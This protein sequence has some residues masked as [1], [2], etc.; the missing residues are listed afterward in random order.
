VTTNKE[1]LA[2][3]EKATPRGVGIQTEIFA[4]KAK[5]AEI[6]DVEGNRYIDLGT[7]IAVLATGHNHPRVIKAVKAQLERFSHTCFQVT[8]YDVYVR[9]AERLNEAAPGATPKKTFFVNTG[10]EAVE[11]TVKIARRYTG[12]SGVIA[13]SGAFHGRTMM[14]MALTG[15]VLPY[16]AGFGP[17]PAEV[18]HVPFP[19]EYH[20]VSV[21]ESLDALQTLFRSDVEPSRIAA[22]VVEPV[23]GEGG[24]YPAPREFLQALR[25]LCDEHGIV[26]AIDEVQTGFGRT[27]TLF[28]CEQAGIEPDLMPVAKS[29]AGGF[30]LAGVIGKA[31][32]MDA[33]DPGGLGST[34]GGSPIGCAAGLAVLDIIEEEGLCARATAIGEQFREWAEAL[35]SQTD[36]VGDIRI[37]GAMCAVEF[38]EGGTADRPAAELTKAIVTDALTQGVLLLTCG[39]RGNVIRFL[40]ALTIEPELLAEALDKTGVI[41]KRLAGEMRK[42][43]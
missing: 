38:V 6:W 2:I 43:S 36:C 33:A 18:Y 13:F 5:N 21:Q 12:R 26:L 8:P 15:K 19:I 1:L 31:E 29:I 37:M 24:F 32:I 10:A 42:A 22:M 34:Y 27:G 41:I 40:P 3:R 7:G 4:D 20:G 14:G 35:Q 9:L 28:A 30:P 17:F 39:V 16:K 23:Q 11:N 25:A